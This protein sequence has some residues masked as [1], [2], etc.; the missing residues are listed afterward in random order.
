MLQQHPA[1]RSFMWC[2]ETSTK[3]SCTAIVP[4]LPSLASAAAAAAAG[5]LG[6]AMGEPWEPVLLAVPEFQC[7]L[8]RELQDVGLKLGQ[9][10]ARA[11]QRLAK[12]ERENGELRTRFERRY[13]CSTVAERTP[14]ASESDE[15]AGPAIVPMCRLQLVPSSVPENGDAPAAD[16][17][18]CREG[19]TSRLAGMAETLHVPAISRRQSQCS[20][21]SKCSAS[22]A[23]AFAS[24]AGEPAPRS[25]AADADE[26]G[27]KGSA[28]VVPERH[29]AHL[30]VWN[31]VSTLAKGLSPSKSKLKSLT[32]KTDM[33]SQGIASEA[34]SLHSDGDFYFWETYLIFLIIEPNSRVNLIWSLLGHALLICDLVATPMDL[35]FFALEYMPWRLRMLQA[36]AVFWT[37]DMVISMLTGYI[38]CHG[39]MVE[40]RPRYVVRRYVR[41]RFLFDISIVVGTYAAT[42][43]SPSSAGRDVF[44][45]LHS[46][47]L[48]RC[49]RLLELA[50]NM[51]KYTEAINCSEKDLLVVGIA[52]LML[53]LVLLVHLLACAWHSLRHVGPASSTRPDILDDYTTAFI[54]CLMLLFGEQTEQSQTYWQRSFDIAVL[55]FAFVLSAAIVGSLTAAITRLQIIASQQSAQF[56]ILGRY[57]SDHN[58]SRELTLRVKRNVRHALLER[59]KHTPE[60]SVTFMALVSKPL[61]AEMHYEMHLPVI[62]EYPFLHVFNIFNPTTTRNICHTALS[63]VLVSRG[64]ILFSM[65]EVS[66]SPAMLF[67]VSGEITYVRGSDLAVQQVIKGEWL[68]EASLWTAWTHCGTARGRDEAQVLALDASRFGE[69]VSAVPGGNGK[70]YAQR[71]V[72]QLNQM[73]DED[74]SDVGRPSVETWEVVD[75]IFENRT[76]SRGRS[77][78]VRSRSTVAS[79]KSLLS[80]KSRASA[81]ASTTE[82]P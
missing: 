82:V 17:G 48:L 56:A 1:A 60:Q 39:L 44:Y 15:G 24:N 54:A 27:S 51:D 22:S 13:S 64:D 26:R 76:F 29:F 32:T 59:R 37:A 5:E 77:R 61:R 42:V 53:I 65:L 18:G 12:L 80:R 81:W 21:V 58:I 63:P 16:K 41:R 7:L 19:A 73:A 70:A 72:E 10:Y 67:V 2:S 30:P 55:L 14:A 79:R 3:A 75:V 28:S 47:R 33:A 50:T 49:G 62:N 43:M 68:A 45:L 34:S 36:S 31:S 25:R 52:A 23:D 11:L 9:E 46:V 57:L 38:T 71:F 40:T 78:H 69:L 20:V 66:M 6:S 4:G 74:L 35:S 8:Q